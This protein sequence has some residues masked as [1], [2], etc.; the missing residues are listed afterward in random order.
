MQEE[1]EDK[2]KDAA[3]Q[4]PKGASGWAPGGASH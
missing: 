2:D 1:T 4:S 3:S